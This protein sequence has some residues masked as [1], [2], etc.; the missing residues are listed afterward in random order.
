MH[1]LFSEVRLILFDLDGTLYEDTHHFDLY[2]RLIQEG[3]PPGVQASFW[4][5]YQRVKEGVHPALRVGT[6]YHVARDLVLHVRAGH[7]SRALTWE[8][9]ELDAATRGELFPHA[10]EVD[11]ETI[12]NVGDLWWVPS[13]VGAHYGGDRQQGQAAFFKVREIMSGTD[14]TISPIPGLKEAL[15][16]LK[17]K[18]TLV[19]ATNS[20]QPDSEAILRKV[21]LE[22]VLDRAYFRSQKPG[23]LLPI[24]EEL[25]ATHG[26]EP[27]QILSVGDNLVNEIVPLRSLGARTVFIDPHGFGEPS[28]ADLVVRTMAELLPT[29]RALG[30]RESTS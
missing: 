12:F 28:D 11:H 30:E 4:H 27:R 21:G 18:I 5:D 25:M 29:L 22:G 8:G 17:G 2:A 10:V 26:L 24:L 7:V 15:L 16:A 9:R 20:P 3:L 1:A 19:L 13:A 23:G 14:F 6:L